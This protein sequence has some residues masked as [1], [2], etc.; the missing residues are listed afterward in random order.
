MEKS[1]ICI[2]DTGAIITLA[3]IDMLHLLDIFFNQIFIPQAVWDELV[4][5]DSFDEVP[6][7][8]AY[9]YNKVKNIKLVNDLKLIMDKGESEAVLLYREYNA[10]VLLIDDR[11]AREI[12]ESLD[13]NCI[14]SLAL[15]IKA[16]EIGEISNL[17]TIFAQL[18]KNKRYFSKQ[19]LNTILRENKEHTI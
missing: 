7:I 14:G 15:L 1:S 8:K 5:D 9:F 12:A 3:G 19:I 13:V 17:K 10:D 18:L 11:K 2:G 4:E 16:K 6:R